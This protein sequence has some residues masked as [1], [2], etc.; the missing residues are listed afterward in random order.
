VFG[1]PSNTP[2]ESVDYFAA[3]GRGALETVRI[4]N[5][6]SILGAPVAD[7]FKTDRISAHFSKN[8]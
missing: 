7:D 2:L 4:I 6:L 8:L 1:S 5:T 3:L